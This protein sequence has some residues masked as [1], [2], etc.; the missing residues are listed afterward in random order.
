M[1]VLRE[2]PLALLAL[3]ARSLLHYCSP[4]PRAR[5]YRPFPS[6]SFFFLFRQ[7]NGPQP[8]THINKQH[9]L[10]FFAADGMTCTWLLFKETGAYNLRPRGDSR[11]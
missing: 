4:A 2:K 8:P 10:I 3:L 11:S 5:L 9:L 6:I 1:S 7:T